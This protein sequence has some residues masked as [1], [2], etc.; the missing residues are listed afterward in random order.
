MSPPCFPFAS[1]KV[2][3]LPITAEAAPAEEGVQQVLEG[4]CRD[5]RGVGVGVRGS[6]IAGVQGCQ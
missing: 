4:V 6:A 5:A 3:V 1:T 2:G